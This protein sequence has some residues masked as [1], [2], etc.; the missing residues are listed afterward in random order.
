VIAGGAGPARRRLGV[1][2]RLGLVGLLAGCAASR[3]ESLRR[4][5]EA[6]FGP[7]GF[8]EEVPSHYWGDPTRDPC[9]RYRPFF[10]DR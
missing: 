4:E 7:R 8:G 10:S 9:W 3:P 2:A 5:D 1:V 6:C